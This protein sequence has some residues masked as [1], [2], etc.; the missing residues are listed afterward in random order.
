MDKMSGDA[1]PGTN[2]VLVSE[3]F[4]TGT[5]SSLSGTFVFKKL[6]PAIY[7]VRASYIGY[8]ST[9]VIADLLNNTTLNLQLELIPT[10]I[11]LNPVTVT[12]S[13]KSEK[14]L[15]APASVTVLETKVLESKTVLTPA[16]HLKALPAVDV[17]TAGLNQSRV[18]VR[19][20]NDLLTGSMLSMVDNRV[21]RVPAIRLNAFQQISTS[22]MDVE[23][24]EIVSGPAS[25]LYGPNSAAGVMHVLTKSPFDSKGT[26]VSIG[27]GE[28]NV[29]IGTLRHAG[30]LSEKLGYKFSVQYY[31]GDD[32]ESV[33]PL[34]EAALEASR[35]A[36]DPDTVRIA[37]RI[38]D[39][40]STNA[41]ARLDYRFSPNTTL[42]LNTGFSN[43]DNI[44]VTDQ[45][46]VQAQD[47]WFYYGQ[48]RFLHKRLFL[49]SFFN[50]INTGDSYLLR[51]GESVINNSGFYAIQAQHVFDLTAG[52]Q[53][54]YGL[55][56]LLTRPSTDGTVNGRNEY[57]DS[58]NEIGAY[59]QSE[60]S[61]ATKLKFIAAAR[62]DHHDRLEGITFSPRAAVVYKPTP[63]HNF[64]ITFNQAFN[65]P[66]SNILFS[67]ID[68]SSVPTAALPGGELLQPFIGDTFLNV[69]SLGTFPDG[70]TYRYGRDNRPMM[71]SAFRM[72]NDYLEADVNEIWPELRE[73]I[74][75]GAPSFLRQS[76]DQSLPEQL[77]QTVPGI[78]QLINPNAQ[79]ESDAYM[80][81]DAAFVQNIERADVMRNTT[82]EFGFKGLLSRRLLAVVDVYHT[83]IKDFIGP[84]K[85]ETPNVFVDSE[86]LQQVLEFDMRANNTSPLVASLISQFVAQNLAPL[87]I[88]VVSPTQVQNGTDVILTYRNLGDVSVSGV[89][90]GLT[91]R[92]NDS[93]NITGNYSFINRDYFKSDDG[94]SDIALNA[95]KHKVGAIL[96]YDS[97]KT[98]FDTSLRFRF[99][100]SFPV[101]SGIYTGEVD[102]Y[103][104]LDLNA[105]Y[106]LPFSR[107]TNL[108]LTILNLTDKKH[109]EFVG[110][111]EIGRLAWFKLTQFL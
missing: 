5:T 12:A 104:V 32:F 62:V 35:R 56:W 75:S 28:R 4:H 60:T 40:V 39:I 13:K 95:P 98:G 23:R 63:V 81:V 57:N 58:V 33:D 25:A 51:T 24:I 65:T 64:R 22:N 89:D 19:G 83:C 9:E 66:T 69:R 107:G 54:T 47:A 30:L 105:N 49:Q 111:P 96:N 97:N 3:Q 70:F 103:A 29:F 73:F 101:L 17:V 16:E 42:I 45:G 76:F 20:F 18:V 11:Q 37:A 14:I 80:P 108:G 2:I 78:Y 55:D 106:R 61:L 99:V 88:G 10:S 52:M 27:G 38:F 86:L 84:L 102:R 26:T 110:V 67:D 36:G 34:E 44:E 92:L 100:D 72:D 109:R 1:L 79:D 82:Y 74:L 91:Y 8:Q 48:I 6:P 15:D 50:K 53:F 94:Y 68:A 93:W 7:T 87:P 59:L 77:S 90:F 21:T 41:D 71:V 85:V 31:Q 46:A 43:G